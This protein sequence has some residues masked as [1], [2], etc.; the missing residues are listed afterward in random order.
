M[1]GRWDPCQ[2]FNAVTKRVEWPK[3]DLGP[4]KVTPIRLEATVSQS[5][6]GATQATFQ[7]VFKTPG[8]W[9]ADEFPP[10]SLP[11]P[12]GFQKGPA[13]GIA[14]LIA[15]DDATGA[16]NFTWWFSAFDLV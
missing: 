2:S 6:T 15:Q 4:E 3:G 5:S 7:T 9:T 10:G 16:V 1:P 13:T 8:R 11:V 14:F 12:G